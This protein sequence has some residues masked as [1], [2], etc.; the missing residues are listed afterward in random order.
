VSAPARPPTLE[1][2]AALAGTS[3]ATVSRVVN[4]NPKVDV[5]VRQ[6]VQKAVD[7]LGYAP[8]RA[9][10]SLVT[11]RTDSIGLVVAESEQ[12]VFN[13]PFFATLVRGASEA[14]AGTEIQLV[15]LLCRSDRERDRAQRFLASHIDGVLLVSAHS[16]DPMVEQLADGSVPA[17][18][19]GRPLRPT[20]LPYVDVDNAGGAELAVEHLA[21]RG[22][23]CIA[24]IAGPQDM[25]PGTD[26]LV[27]FREGMLAAGRSADESLVAFGDFSCGSGAAAA[28]RLLDARA[29]I[30]AIFAASDLM[31][32]GVLQE[33]RRRGLRVP[34]DV[35]VVGFDDSVIAATTRPALTSVHQPVDD[36]G[37]QMIVRL[38]EQMGPAGRTSPA[39]VLPT[40]LVVRDSS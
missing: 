37:R 11:R 35:A 16:D 34:A 22:R 39:T 3:R 12:R 9:A 14:L 1:Q 23:R 21:Q 40:H 38:R 15:L 17:V 6:A 25:A 26:R 29:D 20:S 33:L 8:N 30:D 7:E 31:A 13:E 36:L 2:V 24:T 19:A 10:R 5:A 27:G 18:L 4:G 28:C 32:I